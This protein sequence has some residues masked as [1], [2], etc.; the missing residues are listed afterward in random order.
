MA[1]AKEK[2]KIVLDEYNDMKNEYAELIH[3][4]ALLELFNNPNAKCDI[5]DE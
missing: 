4:E 1:N 3:S 5:F 2:E